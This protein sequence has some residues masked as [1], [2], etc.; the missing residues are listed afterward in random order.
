VQKFQLRQA[1]LFY[2][3]GIALS[4]VAQSTAVAQTTA[5][6]GSGGTEQLEEVVVTGTLIRG[7]NPPGSNVI[8]ISKEQIQSFGANNTEGILANLPQNASF[9]NVSATLPAFGTAFNSRVSIARPNIRNIP[10]CDGAGSGACTLILVDGHRIVPEGTQQTA[11]DPAIIPFGMIERVET[12]VDGNSAIYGSDAVGGVINFI[13]KKNFT[14]TEASAHYGMGKAG[15]NQVDADVTSGTSWDRGF[16][17]VSYSFGRHGDILNGDRSYLHTLDYSTGIPTGRSCDRPNVTVGGVTYGFNGSTYVANSPNVCDNNRYGDLYPIEVRHSG[18]VTLAQDISDTIR[19]DV[20][21]VFSFTNQGD[22]VGPFSGQA[23]ITTRN[24]NY[25]PMPG[26]SPTAPETVQFS[27]GPLLG[28]NSGLNRTTYQVGQV[29]PTLTVDVGADWQV[30]TMFSYGQSNT[31][32]DNS[33]YNSSLANLFLGGPTG[34][35][36]TLPIT[37]ALNP[38]NI[39]ATQN[40]VLFSGLTTNDRGNSI[41]QLI[42]VRSMADGKLI[43]LPGGDL[44]AAVGVE[45]IKDVFRL[46]QTDP[47]SRLLNPY[48]SISQADYA[49]FA[50]LN[51]PI[52]GKSNNIP[53]IAGLNLDASGRYDKYENVI[54]KFVPKLGLTFQPVD[55]ISVT[56]SWGKSFNAPVPSDVAGQLP[57]NQIIGLNPIANT[58]NPGGVVPPGTVLTGPNGSNTLLFLQG[59]EPTLKPQSSTNWSVGADISPPIV[60]N[61]TVGATYYKITIHDVLGLPTSGADQTP[62][63]LYYPSRYVLFP[64][65]AQILAFANSV[66]NSSGTQAIATAAAA[67][68]KIIEII[69]DRFGNVGNY[70]VSGIDFRAHYSH[71]TGFGSLDGTVNGNYKLRRDEQAAPDAPLTHDFYSQGIPRLTSTT[72]LGANIHSLRGQVSW[73]HTSK[74]A[75]SPFLLRIPN[76]PGTTTPLQT[77]IGSYDQFDLF[78]SYSFAGPALAKD[79]ALTLNVENVADK[80]PPGGKFGNGGPTQF[81]P[82]T[83]GRIVEVGFSKKF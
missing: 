15:Y 67:G 37:A 61:L 74:Y 8:G 79:L 1:A 83:L 57:A 24:P 76:F 10:G 6:A 52:V 55:W 50:E 53:G 14:G 39:G 4:V 29:T 45:Y 70:Y 5:S 30:R 33:I 65:A 36:A 35:A 77:E 71:K 66:G 68:Q 44:R 25:V 20:Q 72:T 3:A 48:S 18:Y 7:I 78:F 62:L 56:A 32:Y 47:S 11:V 42:N 38:Y 43:A 22:Y 19:L 26:A 64:T 59:N 23:A 63:F 73:L 13:T 40:R 75:I 80:D 41:N 81:G 28:N 17:M 51:I 54:G 82:H 12:I 21:G 60:D 69:D 46:R 2:L 34:S 16:L 58:A 9:N 49:E 27:Y 31:A